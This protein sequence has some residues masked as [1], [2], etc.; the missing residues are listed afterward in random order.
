MVFLVVCPNT[1]W[2]AFDMLIADLINP[3]TRRGDRPLCNIDTLGPEAGFVKTGQ[4]SDGVTLF[5][6]CDVF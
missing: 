6:V 1:G 2:L 3:N 5:S 4:T